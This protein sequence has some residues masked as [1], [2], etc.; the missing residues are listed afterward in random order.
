MLLVH[1]FRF[2]LCSELVHDPVHHS[3]LTEQLYFCFFITAEHPE[4]LSGIVSQIEIFWFRYGVFIFQ[5]YWRLVD[6]IQSEI[7]HMFPI[8][9]VTDHVIIVAVP[10]QRIRTDNIILSVVLQYLASAVAV[11][12]VL[13]ADLAVLIDRRVDR[14]QNIVCP[15]VFRLDPAFDSDMAPEAFSIILGGQRGQL[16]DQFLAFLFRDEL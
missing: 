13:E 10:D 15:F 5:Y 2:H 9:A 4:N 11:F 7:S 14:V 16:A 12:R 1:F 8:V 3:G 6:T